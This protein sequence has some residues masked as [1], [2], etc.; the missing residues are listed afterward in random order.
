MSNVV[1]KGI[2]LV[3]RKKVRKKVH[4]PSLNVDYNMIMQQ[5]VV[6]DDIFLGWMRGQ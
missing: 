5:N 4:C 1:L 6:A 3:V 2:E